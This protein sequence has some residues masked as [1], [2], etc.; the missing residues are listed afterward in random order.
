[1]CSPA[2]RLAVL[3]G[4]WAA[5]M[6]AVLLYSG[7]VYAYLRWFEPSP[8]RRAAGPAHLRCVRYADLPRALRGPA[9][10][11]R[12]DA[13]TGV[14]NRG[15]LE[16][17]GRPHV[18][19]PPRAGRPAS[20]LLIDIDHFKDFNDRFGHAAGDERAE[21][22]RRAT[23]WRRCAPTDPV[24]RFGGEEFVVICDGLRGARRRWRSASASGGPSPAASA[25][26]SPRHRQRRRRD[27]SARMPPTTT[28]CSRLPTGGST[29]RRRPAAIASSVGA[30]PQA[31]SRR[32]RVSP[33]SR[34]FS[35]SHDA[36]P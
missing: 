33:T 24:Y 30:P 12:R 16:S 14:F 13:L 32:Y 2:R 8:G 28:R 11:L 29:R 7:L 31:R 1:M 15:R 34:R 26:T 4:G 5:K 25:A 3:V 18:E 17:H 20:L 10:A 22:H 6:A 27:L 19:R 36:D 35:A 23:S 21:A 9:G